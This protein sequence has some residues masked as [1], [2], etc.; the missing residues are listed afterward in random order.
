MPIFHINNINIHI[1]TSPVCKRIINEKTLNN[2][3]L[4]IESHNWDDLIQ[5]NDANQAMSFFVRDFQDMYNETI[6]TKLIKSKYRSNKPWLT[7]GL[8]KSIG[9]KNKLYA[10][11]HHSKYNTHE[12]F[13]KYKRYR[14]KLNHLLRIAE[15]NYYTSFIDNNK[16]NLGKLWQVINSVIGKNKQNIINAKFKY[17]GVVLSDKKEIANNFNKFFINAG[18]NLA[19]SIPLSDKDSSFYLKGNYLSSL[20]FHPIVEDDIRVII[21]SLRNS[22]AGWDEVDPKAVKYVSTAIL[23]PL[24]FIVNLS[25]TTGVFPD[26]LKIAKI[27]PLYKK[28]DPE[29]FTNYRPISVLPFF[30]KIFEKVVYNQLIAFLEKHQ[31]LYDFQFGF[32][33]GYSTEMAV[34]YLINKV[35][36]AL[37]RRSFAVS[38]FLDLSKA[39]DTV[40]HQI[41][42][43][44]LSHYG[45]RG[46]PL[47]WFISYMSNRKQ[48]VSFQNA[49]SSNLTVTCGVPQGSILGPLLFLLYINDLGT[50]S[51]DFLSLLFA[52]DTSL[53]FVGHDLNVLETKINFSVNLVIEWFNSNRLSVNLD[54]TNYMIFQRR[55]YSFN[56]HSLVIK[57][58]DKYL[59]Q[60][61][62]CKFLGIWIDENLNWKYH[63]SQISNKLSK[64]VGIFTKIRWKFG[65]NIL[66]QLYYSLAYPHFI[67]CNTSWASTYV[68]NLSRIVILQKKLVRIINFSDYNAHTDPLFSNLKILK[69]EQ[70]NIYLTGIFVYKVTHELMPNIFQNFFRFNSDVHFH[71]TRNKENLYVP[72]YKTNVCKFAVRY[73]GPIVWN[74]IPLDVRKIL[75]LCLFKKKLKSLLLTR[76]M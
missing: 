40:N 52:D 4:Q 69:F 29:L 26:V 47:Q 34:N 31:I 30:S 37:D 43:S 55:N 33:R 58:N 63:I 32:R 72:Q 5:S 2:L 46:L 53:L 39:F 12:K 76:S 23:Q 27:I 11:Y 68:T 22:A 73:H 60:T 10:N 65:K 64:I 41:I 48:F 38:I 15:K 49:E 42:F 56:P 28:G 25:L 8:I 7:F 36:E 67:Y 9:R 50:V 20:Y 16:Q 57:A 62:Y 18:P 51:E 74:M 59:K 17:N 24:T 3:K 61:S 71:S 75:S 44:K 66:S 70:I 6:P 1:H 14:N 13:E 54:K 19:K 45:V 35:S 21:H